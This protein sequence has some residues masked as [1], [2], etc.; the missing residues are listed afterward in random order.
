MLHTDIPTRGEMK[1]LA[2]VTDPWCVSIYTPTEPGT[3]NPDEGRIEFS[4]QV[5]RALDLVTAPD[6][7]AALQEE[8]DALL[9]GPSCAVDVTGRAQ[10]ATTCVLHPGSRR[11]VSPLGPPDTPAATTHRWV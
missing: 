6:A 8:F 5:R 1:A 4:N 11:S 9:E 10:E 7:R 3:A 2:A